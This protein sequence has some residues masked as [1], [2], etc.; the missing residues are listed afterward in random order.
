[1][2][3][4][5]SSAFSPQPAL[6]GDGLVRPALRGAFECLLLLVQVLDQLPET[7]SLLGV[8]RLGQN[9]GD[10]LSVVAKP[11]HDLLRQRHVQTRGGSELARICIQDRVEFFEPRSHQLV[12]GEL[13]DTR[14]LQQQELDQ[15]LFATRTEL[16]GARQE[17]DH[18]LI[19]GEQPLPELAPHY[20]FRRAFGVIE[21]AREAFQGL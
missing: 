4:E 16:E 5:F 21:Q 8:H 19:A 3:D 6:V 1:M 14:H 13:P 9:G 20:S 10:A 18:L 7:F 2:S 11:L 17:R 15:E 12:D